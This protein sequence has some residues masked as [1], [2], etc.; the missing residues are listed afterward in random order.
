MCVEPFTSPEL[1][2]R[3]R[4]SP[5]LSSSP[6]PSTYFCPDP[7]F[8]HPRFLTHYFF[9][10]LWLTLA[11]SSRVMP[12]NAMCG[13]STKQVCPSHAHAAKAYSLVHPWIAG[14]SSFHITWQCALTGVAGVLAKRRTIN[15]LPHDRSIT[16]PPFASAVEVVVRCR[17]GARRSRICTRRVA[18]WVGRWPTL[19]KVEDEL[20]LLVNARETGL[21]K[22]V[23]PSPLI[24]I[25]DVGSAEKLLCVLGAP[26]GQS[27]T[28][29]ISHAHVASLPKRLESFRARAEQLPH[30]LLDGE[31]P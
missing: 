30:R 1:A 18:R 8:S 4:H 12:A 24:Q 13:C 6:A 16:V 28:A 5:L 25:A 15:P 10:G 3:H 19:E 7:S 2:N 22:A 14:C 9:L 23:A 11:A 17:P 20:V 26:T 29:A 21:R 31:E 27:C